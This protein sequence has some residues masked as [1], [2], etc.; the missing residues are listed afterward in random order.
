MPLPIYFNPSDTSPLEIFNP[1]VCIDAETT[2]LNWQNDTLELVQICLPH[3]AV[4]IFDKAHIPY[5]TL[6]NL[7]GSSGTLKIFHHAMFDLRFVVKLLDC[8]VSTAACT[9]I[10]S[11]LINP[12]RPNHSLFSLLDEHLAI[13]LDKTLSTSDWSSQVLTDAQITYAAKDTEHLYPLY[14]TLLSKIQQLHKEHILQDVFNFIPHQVHLNLCGI[15]NIYA[16]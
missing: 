6:S 15:D 11:K 10:M 2:G 9:K 13:T 8:T 1:V 14:T 4:Y 16:Y 3:Q 5:Q 12:Q 7:L